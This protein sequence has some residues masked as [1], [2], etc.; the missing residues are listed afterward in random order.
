MKRVASHKILPFPPSNSFHY[1]SN[2]EL[3]Q[4]LMRAVFAYKNNVLES[5]LMFCQEVSCWRD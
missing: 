2:P 4:G 1:V 3:K 5:A